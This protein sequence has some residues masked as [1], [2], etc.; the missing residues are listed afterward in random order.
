[1]TTEEIKKLLELPEHLDRLTEKQL[2]S[3]SLQ[4]Q[5]EICGEKM[6]PSGLAVHRK[7]CEKIVLIKEQIRIL[8]NES[9]SDVEIARKLNISS[10]SITRY[11]KDLDLIGNNM[12]ELTPLE[13]EILVSKIYHNG[14]RPSSIQISKITGFSRSLVCKSLK[15]LGLESWTD[16]IQREDE[17]IYL[18]ERSNGL[19]GNQISKKYNFTNLKVNRMK[20]KFNK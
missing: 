11:R 19:N 18:M 5:C 10:Q 1:M 6:N 16:I 14:E 7:E 12:Q 17:E 8:H 15:N 2:E 13:K 4:I 3:Y 9:L 20:N